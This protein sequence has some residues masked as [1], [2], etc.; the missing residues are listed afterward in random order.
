MRT[1]RIP[2]LLTAALLMACGR[3]EARDAD[4]PSRPATDTPAPL[5]PGQAAGDSLE[6]VAHVGGVTLEHLRERGEDPRIR[7]ARV[8]V[9]DSVVLVEEFSEGLELVAYWPLSGERTLAL[10]ANAAPG[11]ACERNYRV[12][13][14]RP[15]G[16]V[17]LT[18]EFGSCTWETDSLWFD[19]SGALWVRFPPFYRASDAAEPGF[20]PG[21]PETW[22]YRGA[23]TLERAP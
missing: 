12:L 9:R 16:Q 20:A 21:P 17:H 3:D 11:T 19:R 7:E 13:E 22:V 6:V 2:F 5:S 14:V 18:P 15:D 23:G 8:K 4:A 1:V 10:L